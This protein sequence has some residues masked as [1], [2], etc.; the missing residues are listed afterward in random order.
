VVPIVIGKAGQLELVPPG[1]AGYLWDT[2]DELVDHSRRL[3]AEPSAR[4]AMADAAVA[5]ADR[6][7]RP[8]FAA[9]LNELVARLG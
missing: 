7:L 4:A 3:I 9:R 6:F 2:L 1:Q 8:A 5:E